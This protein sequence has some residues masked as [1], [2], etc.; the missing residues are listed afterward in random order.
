MPSLR[1]LLAPALVAAAMAQT[2]PTN[3]TG[4]SCNLGWTGPPVVLSALNAS[5]LLANFGLVSPVQPPMPMPLGVPEACF[6]MN[7]PCCYALQL[8]QVLATAAGMNVTIPAAACP[9][10]Q[11][12]SISFGVPSS[13]CSTVL[14]QITSLAFA[15]QSS[16]VTGAM[17]A[18]TGT[19]NSNTAANS[20]L[21]CSSSSA[22]RLYTFAAALVALAVAAL[23]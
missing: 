15:G 14:P 1:I 7:M 20:T 10:S 17:L 6:Q 5:G 4:V 16:S 3:P 19:N 9:T 23:F 2:C 22:S 13:Q 8:T 21:A 11:T 18:V 12:V